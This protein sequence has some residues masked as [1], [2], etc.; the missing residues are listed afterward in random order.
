[1]I[2]YKNLI[3]DKDQIHNLYETNKWYAYSRNHEELFGAIQNSLDCI[4]A[5]DG[6]KLV[7]L[8]RTIGDKHSIVFVVSFTRAKRLNHKRSRKVALSFFLN[9]PC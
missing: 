7:G 2:E 3:F 6:D 9:T 8:V 5:Y 4:G 1:M